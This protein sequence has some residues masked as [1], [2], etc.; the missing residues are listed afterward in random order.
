MPDADDYEPVYEDGGWKYKRKNRPDNPSKNPS[1]IE[2]I[3]K[4]AMPMPNELK[5]I[6]IAKK[7]CETYQFKTLDKVIYRYNNS[8]L[9]VAE[10]EAF[11]EHEAQKLSGSNAHSA[12]R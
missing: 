6:P 1:T 7:L 11:I 12:I 4:E 10:G 9:Y 5:H 2:P 3:H 8:G